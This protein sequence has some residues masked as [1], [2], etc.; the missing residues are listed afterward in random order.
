MKLIRNIVLSAA[1]AS[2]ANAAAQRLPAIDPN[3]YSEEQMQAASEFEAA[4]N[5]PVSG[6]FLLMMHSP[7]VMSRARAFGDYLRYNSAIGNTLSELVILITAREWTQDYEWYAHYPIAL[8][9]GID[10]GIADAIAEGRRPPGM[11]EDEE[12]GLRFFHRTSPQ[13]PRQRG[14]FPARAGA[15]RKQGSHRSDGHQR[16]LHVSGHANEHGAV[17]GARKCGETAALPRLVVANRQVRHQAVVAKSRLGFLVHRIGFVFAKQQI[18]GDPPVCQGAFRANAGKARNHHQIR[19]GFSKVVAQLGD[20]R[21]FCRGQRVDA[22]IALHITQ[23]RL[24]NVETEQTQMPCRAFPAP[25]NF[26]FGEFLLP[27][28]IE[29]A[30]I[31]A[32]EMPANL[33]DW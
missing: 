30:D 7:A 16:L 6:P 24:V 4:R 32:L 14:D 29:V 5:R 13:S 26:S 2:M 27:Y 31:G 3:D 22:G 20:I 21:K 1:A 28:G 25:L 10:Q 9:V 15:V 17:A 23:V 18:R 33:D 11:S 19:I 12:I 8:E